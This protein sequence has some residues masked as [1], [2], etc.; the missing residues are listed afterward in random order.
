MQKHMR[1][2]VYKDRLYMM[3]EHPG[4]SGFQQWD[5]YHYY[6]VMGYKA[7]NNRSGIIHEYRPSGRG[8]FRIEDG[9]LPDYQPRY[10]EAA[11]IQWL[12]ANIWQ[13]ITPMNQEC[14]G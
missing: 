7:Q 2:R 6:I 11:A 12:K 9:H 4:L 10:E 3:S 14:Q 1:G 13:R 5:K 8:L